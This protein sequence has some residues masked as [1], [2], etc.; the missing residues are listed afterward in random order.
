MGRLAPVRH[1][2]DEVVIA[3]RRL[4]QR[5]P[6]V[7]RRAGV[8][9]MVVHEEVAAHP[10]LAGAAG[11]LD[12]AVL[13]E[14][15][16]ARRPLHGQRVGEERGAAGLDGLKDILFRGEGDR[17]AAAHEAVRAVGVALPDVDLEVAQLDVYGVRV[18]GPCPARVDAAQEDDGVAD[19]AA[20]R[21]DQGGVGVRP[22]ARRAADLFRLRTERR[23]ERRYI[24]QVAGPR[25]PPH[26]RTC[27]A[28]LV[29]VR[30]GGGGRGVDRR[31]PVVAAR[32]QGRAQQ[33]NRPDEGRPGA[34][35]HGVSVREGGRVPRLLYPIR[36][37]RGNIV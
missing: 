19:A 9:R 11:Q 1:P 14:D 25:N 37:R 21:I 18:P 7:G 30:R 2:A 23:P 20:L 15:A 26:D 16:G 24:G 13:V 3:R 33:R 10:E 4:R 27:R 36:P 32:Q 31:R 8:V 29:F 28:F 5:E 22:V 12:D 35:V 34:S 6:A 17:I